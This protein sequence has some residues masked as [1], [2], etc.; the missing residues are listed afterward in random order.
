MHKVEEGKEEERRESSSSSSSSSGIDDNLFDS[1]DENIDD[2]DQDI[3]ERAVGT[4][5]TTDTPMAEGTCMVA[6]TE[7]LVKEPVEGMEISVVEQD[8]NA[9]N[10]EGA[11]ERTG[12]CLDAGSA[13]GKDTMYMYQAL[14]VHV[15]IGIIHADY[16]SL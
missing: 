16:C 14:I 4:V 10:Q 15:S 3:S 11:A 13:T 5:D 8:V 12:V 7:K 1:L 9:S 2:P 6:D